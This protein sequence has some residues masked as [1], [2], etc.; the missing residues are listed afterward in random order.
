MKGTEQRH[1]RRLVRTY[2]KD[3]L[4]PG[5]VY[6]MGGGEYI[7]KD[8]NGSIRNAVKTVKMKDGSLQRVRMSKKERLRQ[9]Q[10]RALQALPI[11][12]PAPPSDPV[13]P[14]VSL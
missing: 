4:V 11:V 12:E 1:N 5:K 10:I 8:E 2:N 13:S 7:I 6:N 3:K 14:S 9:R